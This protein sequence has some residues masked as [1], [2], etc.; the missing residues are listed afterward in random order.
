[1][2][3]TLNI[4]LVG[5]LFLVYYLTGLLYTHNQDLVDAV[6]TFIL[7]SVVIAVANT[8]SDIAKQFLQGMKLFKVCMIIE[9]SCMVTFLILA[10]VMGFI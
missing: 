2:I 7:F 8:N 3:N 6:R 4:I 5:N 10:G 1:M 9:G